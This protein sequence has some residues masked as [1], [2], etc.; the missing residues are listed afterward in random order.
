MNQNVP[1]EALIT[2]DCI[3]VVGKSNK[4][5]FDLGLKQYQGLTYSPAVKKG[6]L[7]C[8]SALTSVDMETGKFIAGD[9]VEQ[10]RQVLVNAQKILG[11]VNLGWDDLMMAID[12]IVPEAHQT[13]AGTAAVRHEFFQES[14][15]PST[16]VIQEQLIG[17][18]GLLLNLDLI[19][20]T[21]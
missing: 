12:F 21:D 7:V 10:Q 3:A 16:G 19:A 8:L 13:Y 18:K 4:E 5:M 1:A 17:D 9:V 14:L 15:P 11:A 20:A 2:V 6:K